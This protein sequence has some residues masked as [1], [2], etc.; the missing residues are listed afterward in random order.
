MNLEIVLEIDDF[1]K[2]IKMYNHD[3][4]LLFDIKID[5]FI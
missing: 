5:Y 1:L 2:K 4:L 3:E